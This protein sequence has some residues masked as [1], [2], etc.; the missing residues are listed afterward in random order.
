MKK[1]ASVVKT[2]RG[3]G[4]VIGRK[5]MVGVAV[6]MQIVGVMGRMSVVE[7]VTMVEAAMETVIGAVGEG[8][9]QG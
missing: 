6:G 7:T 5:A 1:T 4:A 9:R 3:L 2:V 8:C